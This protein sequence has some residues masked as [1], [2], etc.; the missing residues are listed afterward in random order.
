MLSLIASLGGLLV[1][2]AIGSAQASGP[3]RVCEANPR[4]FT[5]GSGEAIYLTGSHTWSNLQDIGLTDPPP[6]FDY[7]AY[8]DFLQEHHHNFIRLWRLE[9][10]QWSEK[11]GDGTRLKY[12]APH[13]W[14]RTGPGQALDG[15]PR[16]DLEQLDE[17]YFARLRARVMAARERGMYVS[18]MLFEGWGLRFSSWDGHPMNIANN[19]NGLN[20]DPNRDGKGIETHTLQVPAITRIQEAYVRKVV[21]TV[22]DLDNVLYEIANESAL[23]AST[24]GSP[25]WQYHMLGYLKAY[26]ATKPR[27]H[28]V[29]ITSQGYGGGDDSALL[30]ASAADWISP[31]RDGSDYRL[32][33]PPA[34]GQKVVILDTDHL[35]GLGGDHQ[36]VWKAFVRGYNPIYMDRVAFLVSHFEEDIAPAEDAR[37]AMGQALALADRA[38][39]AAMT[40]HG[41]LVSTQYCLAEPGREYVVYLPEGGEVTVDLSAATGELA[42]E[43]LH[44]VEGVLTP[45]DPLAGGAKC[46]LKAPFAGDAVLHIR[47]EQ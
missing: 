43:W 44:P 1:C 12:C 17:A 16:F 38:N 19:I 45:G 37:R 34:T 13:P 3:L 24:S 15:K 4:Y 28:P 30:L 41:E 22:N 39:L 14:R 26:E 20:G 9:L 5:D 18:I 40:P 25:E 47:R 11:A 21:D 23:L 6:A 42:V 10:T 36:W 8:L 27:Q 29:G 32:D 2:A 46:A 33:P 31:N 35:W 7:T